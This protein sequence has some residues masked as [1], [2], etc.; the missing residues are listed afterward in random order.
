MK[1]RGQNVHPQPS[2]FPFGDWI[3]Q[4][5][6]GPV[7]RLKLSLRPAPPRLNLGTIPSGCPL[8]T[9]PESSSQ[10]AF[11][12]QVVGGTPGHG[13]TGEGG[14]GQ[15]QLLF[16]LAFNALLLLLIQLGEGKGCSIGASLEM[17]LMETYQLVFSCFSTLPPAAI[18]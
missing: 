3:E 5:E 1:A 13:L 8:L 7:A 2:G 18:N 15:G 12:K 4:W 11:V 10:E 14:R 17:P 6:F 16:K 9:L